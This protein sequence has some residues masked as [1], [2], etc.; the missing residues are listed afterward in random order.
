MG[1]V[2]VLALMEIPPYILSMMTMRKLDLL[3]ARPEAAALSI[4][5]GSA[6]LGALVDHAALRLL[7]WL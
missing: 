3:E 4:I 7:P 2:W 1:L 5:V 6:G